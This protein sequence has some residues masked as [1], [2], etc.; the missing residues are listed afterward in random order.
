[1]KEIILL[2]VIVRILVFIL[3]SS[4]YHPDEYYQY[5]EPAYSLVFTSL[6]S[7]S[8]LTWEWRENYQIRSFVPLIPLTTIYSLLRLTNLDYPIIIR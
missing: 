1:M 7:S 2:I 3:L 6:S 8:S 5:N 4:S